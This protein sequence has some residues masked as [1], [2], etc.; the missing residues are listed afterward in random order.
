MKNLFLAGI[1]V[2]G[3]LTLATSQTQDNVQRTDH[4]LTATTQQQQDYREIQVSEVPQNVRTQVSNQYSN[5]RITKAH[6]NAA[7]KYK[8]E[9]QTADNK[10][11]TVE[12]DSK[13][14]RGTMQQNRRQQDQ[15]RDTRQ[16]RQRQQN[17]QNQLHRNN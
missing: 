16:N 2:L 5:S 12:I 17:Q 8:L 4:Q 11:Q 6:V 9:I 1:F 15:N 10:K 3:S 7:G 14:N 13:D